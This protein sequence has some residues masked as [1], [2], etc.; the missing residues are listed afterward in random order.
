MNAH[1]ISN[2]IFGREFGNSFTTIFKELEYIY[3]QYEWEILIMFLNVLHI[4]LQTNLAEKCCIVFKYNFYL[5][6]DY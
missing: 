5:S 1:K 6:R 2:A 3:G 4:K